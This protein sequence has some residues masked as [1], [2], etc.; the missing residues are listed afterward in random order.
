MESNI[1]GLLDITELRISQGF[2]LLESLT[3]GKIKRIKIRL[4]LV[5]IRTDLL[6]CY[7]YGCKKVSPESNAKCQRKPDHVV[8]FLKAKIVDTNEFPETHFF[9]T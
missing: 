9:L 7:S 4:E 6:F 2:R 8:S 5:S 1:P 3:S